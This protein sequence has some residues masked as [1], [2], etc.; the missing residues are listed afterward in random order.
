MVSM[1]ANK[2]KGLNIFKMSD[3]LKNCT[4]DMQCESVFD[5]DYDDL[6][7]K[8]YRFLIFDLD[9]TLVEDNSYDIPNELY[10]LITRLKNTGFEILILSNN[11]ESRIRPIARA[12]DL[13]YIFKAG[14]PKQK[15]YQD[16]EKYFTE[17]EFSKTI[18]IGDQLFTDI[19]GANKNNILTILVDRVS[20]K[21]CFAVKIKRG[22]ENIFKRVVLKNFKF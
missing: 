8:N 12:L 19:Y 21:E 17:F 13:K 4:P 7:D 16:L 9:N 1:T 10:K 15:A 6:Y 2:Q 5:I 22:F 20:S 11:S 14:K 3:F 18:M